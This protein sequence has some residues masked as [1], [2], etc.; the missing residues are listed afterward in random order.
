LKHRNLS[1]VIGILTAILVTVLTTWL[2]L[3]L[4]AADLTSPKPEFTGQVVG[5][6]D[7]DTIDVLH[8]GKTERVRL[9]G[10]DCPEKKQPYGKKAKWFTSDL[11]FRKLR[12]D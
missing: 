2:A 4:Y 11:A 10:I 8:N 12:W 6:V 5:I 9:Y 3:P 7:G 1:L